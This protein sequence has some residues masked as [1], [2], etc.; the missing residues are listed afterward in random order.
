V[1]SNGCSPV[2]RQK[3]SGVLDR[4]AATSTPGHHVSVLSIGGRTLVTRNTTD[5]EALPIRTHNP[6]TS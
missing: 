1:S 2:K 3:N 5:V 4:L 6:F